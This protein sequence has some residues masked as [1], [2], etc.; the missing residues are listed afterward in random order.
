MWPGGLRP[1]TEPHHRV[2]RI[3]SGRATKTDR[4]TLPAANEAA[5]QHTTTRSESFET[6]DLG[7]PRRYGSAVWAATIPQTGRPKCSLRPFGTS[8]AIEMEP[9]PRRKP[10]RE[11]PSDPHRSDG[12]G[13]LPSRS[14]AAAMSVAEGSLTKAALSPRTAGK[15]G[16][17]PT[18]L[19]SLL[20]S[21]PQTLQTATSFSPLPSIL[22]SDIVV[23]G[24]LCLFFL[25]ASCGVLSC[26]DRLSVQR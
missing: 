16:W 4:S 22:P 11:V 5:T 3:K 6:R 20:P 26:F 10:C 8:M 1:P 24:T 9:I 25:Q 21:F 14:L 19:P 18:A 13:T 12:S 17:D 23:V 15:I 2:R 7:A